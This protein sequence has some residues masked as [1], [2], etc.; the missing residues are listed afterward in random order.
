VPS[1][2]AIPSEKLRQAL[3]E[4]R[5]RRSSIYLGLTR[6][7]AK[8]SPSYTDTTKFSR[9]LDDRKSFARRLGIWKISNDRISLTNYGE[10]VKKLLERSPD[11]TNSILL[12]LLL[13][14]P[15]VAYRSFLERLA[16]LGGRF[17][18]DGIYKSRKKERGDFKG[19]LNSAGFLT[20]GASFH[21]IKD[22]FYDFGLLNWRK[23]NLSDEERIFLTRD[24]YEYNN[25]SSL[26]GVISMLTKSIPGSEVNP[27]E[28]ALA[29]IEAFQTLCLE[30]EAY[31]DVIFIR[32]EVCEKLLISDQQFAKLL[33]KLTKSGSASNKGIVTGVGP[34][35]TKI[36]MGYAS[37]LAKLPFIFEGE[38]ITKLMVRA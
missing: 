37:K 12:D 24:L 5:V 10:M 20:D 31:H 36:P 34:L 16:V 21:T 15:Y 38:P 29:I 8:G 4:A 28:F 17:R 32:D 26:A 25:I 1:H 30:R 13:K 11:M 3:L 14:S 19:F 7:R 23:D 18:I 35:V 6:K 33:L 2:G 27:G 9:L 22:L